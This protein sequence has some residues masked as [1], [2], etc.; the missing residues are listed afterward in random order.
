M[1][2]QQTS[3]FLQQQ[4]LRPKLPSV[5]TKR[6]PNRG[7]HLLN[8][9]FIHV[10]RSPLCRGKDHPVRALMEMSGVPSA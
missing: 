2:A 8:L 9:A 7:G 4:A 1:S 5:Q 6:F 10:D 3:D